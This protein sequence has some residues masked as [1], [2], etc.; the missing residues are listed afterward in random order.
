MGVVM[1]ILLVRKLLGDSWLA[2]RSSLGCGSTWGRSLLLLALRRNVLLGVSLVP[3]IVVSSL[4][5]VRVNV[6]CL[7]VRVCDCV[8]RLMHGAVVLIL[9]QWFEVQ[10]AVRVVPMEGL[11][12]ELV[13]LTTAMIAMDS[14]TV[15]IMMLVLMFV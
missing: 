3:S 6:W 2:G 14:G 1:N 11:V 10:V 13:V 9:A 7:V 5:V 8:V 12:V 15:V 4:V